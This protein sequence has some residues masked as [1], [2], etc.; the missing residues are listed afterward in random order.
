MR[1]LFIFTY[2]T[3]NVLSQNSHAQDNIAFDFPIHVKVSAD[4]VYKNVLNHHL[5]N[6][7]RELPDV[8]LVSLENAYDQISIV[9]LQTSSGLYIASLVVN[10][11]IE[12][13][14]VIT[15]GLMLSDQGEELIN[16][17]SKLN[18]AI[19]NFKNTSIGQSYSSTLEDALKFTFHSI[20]T[21]SDL[22]SLAER[23]VADINVEIFQKQRNLI[24]DLNQ[25]Q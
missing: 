6:H 11:I 17:K 5:T 9:S 14:S 4:E 13:E 16:D 19:I 12:N 10:T 24:E 25:D 7:F 15:M 23:I 8:K 18:E 3:L 20:Y 1:L 22:K 2:L 21:D